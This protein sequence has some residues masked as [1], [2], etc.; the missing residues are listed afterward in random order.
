MVR[1]MEVYRKLEVRCMFLTLCIWR[2]CIG[3]HSFLPSLLPSSQLTHFV[4]FTLTSLS[5]RKKVEVV[6]RKLIT[7]TNDGTYKTSI[8]NRFL[9]F[10]IS[11]HAVPHPT[12]PF[13]SPSPSSLPQHRESH[14]RIGKLSRFNPQCSSSRCRLEP[15]YTARYTERY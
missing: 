14:R 11:L 4:S 6:V 13:Y 12:H 7:N 9:L 3:F 1:Y 8:I 5:I 10:P 2:L 15:V